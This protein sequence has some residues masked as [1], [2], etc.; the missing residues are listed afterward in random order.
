MVAATGF[1]WAY[2][3]TIFDSH[4]ATLEKTEDVGV[5]RPGVSVPFVATAYCKGL[6]TTAGVA[7][8]SGIA[9]ADPTL[10]P[11]GSVVQLASLDEAHNG[12]YAVLDTGPNVVG[13]ILDI[14]MWN[15][16]EALRFGRRPTTLTVMRLGWNPQATTPSLMKRLFK[17]AE[18]APPPPLPSRPLP[19]L[20]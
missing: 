13:R 12:I 4:V 1:V 11:I 2:Q 9:A 18:P 3:T 8:Q 14:Y 10:L 19:V 6:L 17:R 20:Q 5:P 15:C 16:N 7:A